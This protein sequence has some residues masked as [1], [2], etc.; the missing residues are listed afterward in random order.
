M[1]LF[2]RDDDIESAG[3]PL[4]FF[5]H[6]VGNGNVFQKLLKGRAGE[7]LVRFFTSAEKNLRLHFVSFAEKL[8]RLIFFEREIVLVRAQSDTDP[9]R[10]HFLLMRFVLAELLG[11][12]IV[13]FSMIQNA[14]YGRSRFGRYFNEIESSFRR[15]R[16]CLLDRHLAMTFSFFIDHDDAWCENGIVRAHL[17][18]DVLSFWFSAESSSHDMTYGKFI[19]YKKPCAWSSLL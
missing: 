13:K 4:E 8:L 15:K 3:E 9:F 14:A 2:R 19:A 5:L 18:N 16:A 1:S 17:R 7:V 11:L 10:F 12:L 6:A